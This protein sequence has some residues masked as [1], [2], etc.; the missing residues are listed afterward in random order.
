[1]MVE[2]NSRRLRRLTE[3]VGWT[4]EGPAVSMPAMEEKIRHK[5]LKKIFPVRSGTTEHMN[6]VWPCSAGQSSNIRPR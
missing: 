1:M 2:E 5:Y 3:A 6:T 4:L